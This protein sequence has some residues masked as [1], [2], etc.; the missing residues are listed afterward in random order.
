MYRLQ[1][2]FFYNS[3]RKT[4]AANGRGKTRPLQTIK[5]VFSLLVFLAH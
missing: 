3:G 1:V 4:P 5:I 2:R